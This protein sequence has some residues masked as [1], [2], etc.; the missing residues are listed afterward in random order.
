MHH[1]ECGPQPCSLKNLRISNI[2]VYIPNANLFTSSAQVGMFESSISTFLSL[3][4]TP[5]MSG[6]NQKLLSK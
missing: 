6:Y 2:P 1:T 5:G 4:K 3:G